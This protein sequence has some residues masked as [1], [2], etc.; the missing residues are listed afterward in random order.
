MLF[1]VPLRPFNKD[2]EALDGSQPDFVLFPLHML[3]LIQY[4]Y[5]QTYGRT[6][7]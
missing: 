4:T 2:I 5:L 6:V 3:E 7:A 1:S